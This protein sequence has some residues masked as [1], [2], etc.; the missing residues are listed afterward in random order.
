VQSTLRFARAT[1]TSDSYS[2]DKF[3]HA[4]A[5]THSAATYHTRADSIFA[6]T[7]SRTTAESIAKSEV[8]GS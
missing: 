2:A 4:R 8:M 6:A 5:T 7:Y 3:G 1:D